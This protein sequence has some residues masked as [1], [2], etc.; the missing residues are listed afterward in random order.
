MLARFL[1][2][3]A[4]RF[5][6]C[7]I[8]L[9]LNLLGKRPDGFHEIE[10]ILQPLPLADR[11]NFGESPAGTIALTCDEP[12]LPVDSRNLVHRAAT[13]FFSTTGINSGIKI[14]LEKR[15]PLAAGLGGGSS[16]AAVTL[17]ALNELF[18][19]PLTPSQMEDLAKSLG[20]DVPFFLQDKPAIGLGRGEQ[21]TP[22]EPFPCLKDRGL[23][24]IHPGFGIPTA[25]VYQN[26]S[27]FPE[28]CNG[29]KGRAVELAAHLQSGKLEGAAAHF[30]NA[31]EAPVLPK[32]PLLILFQEFLKA[33]GVIVTMMSGSGSTTFAIVEDATALKRIE[34]VFRERFGPSPWT[35]SL[36][37]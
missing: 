8:N 35:A 16:N 17:L 27:R 20:S 11:L 34:T 29:R 6:P 5:S 15:V 18:D 36:L 32:Y 19:H 25:W 7:K 31:L 14:H 28:S 4:E 13:L 1:F 37:L 12:K 2:M 9:V 22:L 3:K 21:I 33:H 10:T 26:M 23:F 30:Y 24:L